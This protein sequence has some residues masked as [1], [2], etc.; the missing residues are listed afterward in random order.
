[1][2]RCCLLV[3]FRKAAPEHQDLMK[4]KTHTDFAPVNLIY[5][6]ENQRGDFPWLR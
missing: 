4:Q 3:D 2:S 5:V 1:M 6:V